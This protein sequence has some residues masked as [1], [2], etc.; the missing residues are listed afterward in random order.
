MMKFG[1]FYFFRIYCILFIDNH[2]AII[3]I[4][5]PLLIILSIEITVIRNIIIIIIFYVKTM[6]IYLLF[7][8]SVNL[9]TYSSVIFLYI[10]ILYLKTNI[11]SKIC[12][13][14]KAIIAGEFH[15]ISIDSEEDIQISVYF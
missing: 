12:G 11:S 15:E 10:Y 4:I 3:S 9:S 5:I 6:I 13:K 2:S 7:N 8:L 14:D 1:N